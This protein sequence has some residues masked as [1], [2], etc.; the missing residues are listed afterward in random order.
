MGELLGKRGSIECHTDV[1]PE[2]K[3]GLFVTCRGYISQTQCPGI[4]WRSIGEY[5]NLC[6][7]H[8][9]KNIS[10]KIIII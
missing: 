3:M 1:G 6:T 4:I 2:H 10:V 8:V 5:D 7:G 9:G